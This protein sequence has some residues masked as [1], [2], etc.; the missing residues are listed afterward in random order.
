M[1]AAALFLALAASAIGS[2]NLD[3]DPG[4]QAVAAEPASSITAPG[5]DTAR[6]T[7]DK[8]PERAP[9]LAVAPRPTPEPAVPPELRAR[10]AETGKPEE[11]VKT[12]PRSEAATGEK[13]AARANKVPAETRVDQ[14]S[15]VRGE[16]SQKAARKAERR[17]EPK[18]ARSARAA[19]NF[20][21]PNVRPREERKKPATRGNRVAEKPAGKPRGRSRTEAGSGEPAPRK[22]K[23]EKNPRGNAMALTI[24]SIG[25]RG[26]PIKTSAGQRAL[27]EGLIRLPNTSRPWDRG[28][29]KNVYVVGHRL[30]WPG[31][32][33]WKVFQNLDKLRRG[34]RLVLTARG[35]TYRYRVSEKLVVSPKDVWVT[36]PVKGRDMLTLQ[37]CTG[38]DYGERLIV[39]ADRV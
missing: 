20:P 31:T 19:E 5:P 13:P 17:Q 33:S 10:S 35:E 9:I 15:R 28:G 34:D 32:G 2:N 7:A 21:E 18:P 25:L 24:E 12:P 39:R 14:P 16:P 27:D 29:T 36:R 26:R 30:G 22:A 6:S 4:P 11:P 23:R 37:T 1:F 38:P 8:V 3:P